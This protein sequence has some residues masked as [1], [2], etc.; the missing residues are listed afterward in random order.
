MSV[1]FCEVSLN[2]ATLA[3]PDAGYRN[4]RFDGVEFFYDSSC[5]IVQCG[6]FGEYF[7]IIFGKVFNL[8]ELLGPVCKLFPVDDLEKLIILKNFY[9]DQLLG[10]LRG[11]FVL[12]FIHLP[13]LEVEIVKSPF[14]CKGLYYANDTSRFVF[15][16]SF[17][18]LKKIFSGQLEID[19]E[20]LVDLLSKNI[21]LS[22]RS[23]YKRIFQVES[24][25]I[26]HWAP[27]K[28]LK[29]QVFC[30]A[31]RGC[32]ESRSLSFYA[33]GLKERLQAAVQHRLTQ[34][35]KVFC[36]ISG[37]LDSTSVAGVLAKQVRTLVGLS[38]YS[39]PHNTFGLKLSEKI[40]NERFLLDFE[41]LHS[42]SKICRYDGL[43]LSK[44]Y[45][46]ITRF[47]FDHSNGPELAPNNLLWLL[48]FYEFSHQQGAK[49]LFSGRLGDFAFSFRTMVNQGL[50][51]NIRST[52]SKM[53]KKCLS[54]SCQGGFESVLLKKEV[55][56]KLPS[57]FSNVI[58]CIQNPSQ[59]RIE[60]LNLSRKSMT[61]TS[62]FSAAAFSQFGIE[63]LDPTS[64]LDLIEYCLTIPVEAYWQNGINRYVTREAMR[65]IIPESVRL[66]QIKGI[67][68]PHWY[69]PLKREL[70]YYKS[71]LS[72][73]S[74]NDLIAEIVDLPRLGKLL[75]EFEALPI[76]KLLLDHRIN[77][78]HALHV[79]EWVILHDE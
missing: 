13:R 65:G 47:C 73:F 24:A 43:S 15:S 68:A 32:E 52:L 61:A 62:N 3:R 56:T 22:E 31:Q 4:V 59:R 64:D 33:D 29:K 10:L 40:T 49:K 63:S 54:Q 17:P 1:F 20:K 18:S 74:K 50:L 35:E 48:S 45:S 37:G 77:L 72:K 36:E 79:C 7:G 58:R 21:F 44:N 78:V 55:L 27:Y 9:R 70:G 67:Q 51:G 30:V 60:L 26:I 57:H 42:N 28:T 71:L 76:H 53:K 19:Q 5:R 2:P 41:A 23:F 25:Q 69:V 8:D 34:E 16:N 12:V 46:E 11:D 6:K 39:T 14:S 38:D 75:R 66:N